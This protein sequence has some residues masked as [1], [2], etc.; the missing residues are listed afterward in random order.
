MV[1]CKLDFERKVWVNEWVIL[2]SLGRYELVYAAMQRLGNRRNA[3][4]QGFGLNWGG[5]PLQSRLL[6]SKRPCLTSVWP[7]LVLFG[8]SER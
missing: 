5:P 7:N 3:A 4:K 1:P 2:A 6:Q 8:A